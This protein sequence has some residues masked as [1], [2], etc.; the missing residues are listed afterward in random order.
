MF[1]G[2]QTSNDPYTHSLGTTNNIFDGNDP[3]IYRMVYG[4]STQ[5]TP[6][7][8][9]GEWYWKFRPTES[10][11]DA[12]FPPLHR[13][14]FDTADPNYTP[15]LGFKWTFHRW[16]NMSRNPANSQIWQNRRQVTGG[17]FTQPYHAI[18]FSSSDQIV[19]S[20]PTT[21]VTSGYDGGAGAVLQ[22]GQWDWMHRSPKTGTT[23][24]KAQGSIGSQA[25]FYALKKIE[26]VVP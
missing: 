21:V 12:N 10:L 9:V 16:H 26:L 13:K 14:Y 8:N 4:N 5:F 25:W 18:S 6:P 11:A 17:T 24:P 23:A 20:T 2:G 19:S 3:M 7:A 22:G 15:A 1:N